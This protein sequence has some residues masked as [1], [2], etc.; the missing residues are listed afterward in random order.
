MH[1]SNGFAPGGHPIS[2]GSADTYHS[3]AWNR[4]SWHLQ[5]SAGGWRCGGWCGLNGDYARRKVVMYKYGQPPYNGPSRGSAPPNGVFLN[6]LSLKNLIRGG[7]KYTINPNG[8]TYNHQVNNR[9]LWPPAHT[10]WLMM[11]CRA[12]GQDVLT[13][14]AFA[15]YAA[16]NPHRNKY[17][18]RRNFMGWEKGVYWYVQSGRSIGFATAGV[19]LNSA[20]TRNDNGQYRMSW[21]FPGTGWRCG[22]QR[23]SNYQ[24]IE[25]IAMYF[26]VTT[27]TTTT[28]TTLVQMHLVTWVLP[29]KISWKIFKGKKIVCQGPS[30][31]TNYAKWYA[32]IPTGCRLKKGKY[33]IECEDKRGWGWSEGYMQVK[34]LHLCKK[35]LWKGEKLVQTFTVK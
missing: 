11:G 10:K 29:E 32:K 5:Q 22:M 24:N 25:R 15:R 21:H 2:L 18:R 31:G 23:G 34:N 12:R 17:H 4:I 28:T 26:G 14:G 1:R 13:L 35:F 3:H 16:I 8:H 27:T 6:R 20:D 30:K 33:S 7:Y 19:S 9:N